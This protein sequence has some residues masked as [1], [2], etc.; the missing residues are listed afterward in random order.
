MRGENVRDQKNTSE[1]Y[2][3]KV[4]TKNPCYAE[5]IVKTFISMR[6]F[7]FY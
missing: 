6:H 7:E 3:I 4:C 1:Q 2:H 5:V